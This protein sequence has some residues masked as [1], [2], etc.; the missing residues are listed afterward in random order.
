MLVTGVGMGRLA[1]NLLAWGQG[2]LRQLAAGDAGGEAEV[3]LDAHA[4]AGLAPG[5][6]ALHTSVLSPSEAP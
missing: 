4:A 1:P 2:P 3:V 6:G 5:P